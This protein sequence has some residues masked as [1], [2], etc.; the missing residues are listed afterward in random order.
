MLRRAAERVNRGGVL[1]IVDHG[2]P[3]PWAEHHHDH[4]FAGIEEVLGS[5][6]LQAPRWTRLRTEAVDREMVGPNGQVGTMAD[7]IMVLRRTG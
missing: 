2:A 3:P 7:N 6:D 5:L 4:H 1:L